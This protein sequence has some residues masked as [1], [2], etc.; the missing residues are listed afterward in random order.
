LVVPKKQREDAKG[1]MWARMAGCRVDE[2]MTTN[3]GCG[4]GDR[5]RSSEATF[6]RFTVGGAFGT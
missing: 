1:L 2:T 5:Q 3:G 6:V 4:G